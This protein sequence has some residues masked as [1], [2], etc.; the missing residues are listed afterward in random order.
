MSSSSGLS[1]LSDLI[2]TCSDLGL[3]P[4][5]EIRDRSESEVECER[6]LIEDSNCS[7]PP[8]PY[9]ES[10]KME[11][12]LEGTVS[13]GSGQEVRELSS[14]SS[15]KVETSNNGES[16]ESGKEAKEVGVPSNILEVDNC[17]VKC[18]NE[19]EEVLSK[20]VGYEAFWKSRSDLTHLVEQH[21]ILGHILLRPARVG[22]GD[23]ATHPQHSLTNHK[24]GSSKEKGWFYFTPGVAG[25]GSRNLFIV[26]PS[27][28]KGWKDKFLFVDDMKWG[29]LDV[30]VMN[31][32]RGKGKKVNPNKYALSVGEQEE[33]E[34]L[35]RKGEKVVDIMLLTSSKML[36]V[37]EIYGPISLS[38][39]DMNWLLFGGKTIAFPE[40]RSNDLG[41]TIVK[42][43]IVGGT[44]RPHPSGRAR[45]E[46]GPN[47]EQRKKGLKRRLHHKKGEGLKR[48]LHHKKGERWKRCSCHSPRLRLSSY[49]S[50]RQ[51]R[52]IQ[53]CWRWEWTAAKQF[54][55]TTFLDVDLEKAKKEVDKN[56]GSSIIQHTLEMVNLV[57]AL[58]KESTEQ[59]FND[60]TSKLEKVK[61]ELATAKKAVELKEKKRK[62]CEENLAK[63]KDELVEV[64]R[65]V[66][67]V[68]EVGR[69]VLP[70]CLE[71]EFIAIDKNEAKVG[72]GTKVA[73][74]ATEQE[75]DQ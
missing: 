6:E 64:Q 70:P 46:T 27:S 35:E 28:I 2:I 16:E 69:I 26:G 65:K 34:R 11:M 44:L 36:K 13:I 24:G 49:L 75:M 25:G 17:R 32:C 29:R 8:T 73:D 19:G 74:N 42:E 67:L 53:L 43:K 55:K 5:R 39:E 14:K 18:Y 41:S 22:V 38:E 59:N 60:L 37:V 50:L 62:K 48:R 71:Y 57:N 7:P 68:D 33:V 21:T 12:S 4:T 45:A 9:N 56:G 72:G 54:N 1:E 20:V 63:A 61:E 52:L 31:L 10:S 66:E 15:S 30:E 23:N 40:K 47:L 51:C 58:T 3:S